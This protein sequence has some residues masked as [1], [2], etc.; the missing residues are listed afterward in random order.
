MG[1]KEGVQVRVC[2]WERGRC[3]SE[4]VSGGEGRWQMSV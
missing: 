1:V 4:C 2:E 3:A